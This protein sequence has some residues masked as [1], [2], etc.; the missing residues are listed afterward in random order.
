M[1][2]ISSAAW[3]D[4][5]WLLVV[6]PDGKVHRNQK[7][8]GALVELEPWHFPEFAAPVDLVETVLHTIAYGIQTARE[9]GNPAEMVMQHEEADFKARLLKYAGG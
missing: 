4:A 2:L 6:N 7:V 8:D 1:I 5:E 3:L 9:I